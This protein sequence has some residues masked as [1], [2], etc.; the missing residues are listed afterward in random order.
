MDYHVRGIA[1]TTGMSVEFNVSAYDKQHVIE[2]AHA[3][4]ITPEE[5]ELIAESSKED[6]PS[7][8]LSPPPSPNRPH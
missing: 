5:I 6:R 4:G 8:A 2:L 7:V 3:Q 1:Q